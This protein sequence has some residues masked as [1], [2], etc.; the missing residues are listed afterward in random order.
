MSAI[1]GE[2]CDNGVDDDGNGYIDDIN[3]WNFYNGD[4]D[5][6]DTHGH[7][8]FCAGIIAANAVLLSALLAAVRC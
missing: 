8:T 6:R 5:T 1:C 7:G 2:V 3:G 4:P